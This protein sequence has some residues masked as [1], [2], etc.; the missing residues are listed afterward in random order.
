MDLITIL[1]KEQNELLF[2]C[3]EQLK[4][5]GYKRKKIK[6][7]KDYLYAKGKI[8]VLLVAH[9][10]TVHHEKPKTVLYDKEKQMLWSPEGIG[11]DD[12]CGVYAILKIIQNFEPY[13]LFTTD[14]EIGG[15]GAT[16][17]VNENFEVPV[18]FIIEID[19]RGNKQAVFYD[20][21]NEEFKEVIEAL[22]FVEKYGTFSD[23]SIISPAFDIAS[24]NLS[25][26][27]YNEHTKYEYI[28]LL[29]LDFTITSIENLLEIVKTHEVFNN[30]RFD[31]EPLA[32]AYP[33][34]EYGE[35]KNYSYFNNYDND[36]F[37]YALQEDWNG[38]SNEEWYRYYG[39]EKPKS[40]ETVKKIEKL[41]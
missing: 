25:A 10:D 37:L 4:R 24:V 6:L 22:G 20:C 33:V 18:N 31:Y 40:F 8:P 2:Y 28:N 11:G 12:R 23:I 1:K 27:Y 30:I 41:L 13:I 16:K 36:N 38:L 3:Y 21:G 14:E 32:K 5:A 7:T 9:L 26:G 34:E 29:H 15:V 17:F 19:R 39:Y 35:N